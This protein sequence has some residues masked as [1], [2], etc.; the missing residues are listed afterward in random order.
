MRHCFV[1]FV[2]GAVMLSVLFVH[3]IQRTVAIRS[4]ITLFKRDEV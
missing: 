4:L 1:V 2:V 3:F